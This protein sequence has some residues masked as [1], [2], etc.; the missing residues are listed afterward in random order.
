MRMRIAPFL[1]AFGSGAALTLLAGGSAR[2]QQIDVNPPLPN[3]LLMVD[4][5]GSMERMIDGSLPEDTT[6]NACDI[7]NC[8]VTA[9]SPPTTA[10]TVATRMSPQTTYPPPNRWNTALQA[11]T[12]TPKNG[13]HCIAMSRTGGVSSTFQNEY[14]INGAAPY[15]TGFYLPYHR[16]V[17]IDP[18][19]NKPCVFA[20]GSL[21]GETTGGV[22][23]VPSNAG[24]SASSFPNGSIINRPYGQSVTTSSCNFAQNPD[25]LLD[26]FQ[27]LIRFG[28]M[29]FDQ[30][31]SAATGV[32]AVAGNPQVLP[33]AG[34][35]FTG[36]WSYFP[37]W[38]GSSASVPA[39]GKPLLCTS[40]A[41]TFEVGAR[42]PAAPPWEGRMMYFPSDE[43]QATRDLQSTNM[44]LV[45]NATRPYGGTPLAGMFADAQ[46][47]FTTDPNGPSNSSV[48]ALAAGGCRQQFII[49]L[50]DGAPNEDMRPEYLGG[51]LYS[52]GCGT[53]D[54]SSLGTCPYNHPEYTAGQ[55]ANNPPAGQKPV[56]T[57]VVGF[58]VSSALNDQG[59]NVNCEQINPVTD[60]ANLNANSTLAPCCELQKIAVAGAPPQP[61]GQTAHA[62][63]ANNA[64][65]LQAALGAI[66]SQIASMQ[67]TR[68]VPAYSSV[69]S[70]LSGTTTPNQETFYGRFSPAPAIPPPPGSLASVGE[71]WSGDITRSRFLC[72]SGLQAPAP[73]DDFANDLNT[74]SPARYFIAVPA[75][76]G[77]TATDSSA[78]LR[79]FFASATGVDGLGNASVTAYAGSASS[80]VN[81]I[82]PGA[83]N[84]SVG[85]CPY[86]SK[87]T[88]TTQSP[89]L[90]PTQCANMLMDFTFGQAFNGPADFTFVSRTS[91]AFGGVFH[92]IPVAVGPPSASLHDDSYNAFSTTANVVACNPASAN[93]A[94]GTGCR[95]N[96]LYAATTDGILHAFWTD[97]PSAT[98]SNNEMWAMVPPGVLPN[99]LSSYPAEDKFLLDGSPVV[100]DVV[101]DRPKGQA[102]DPNGNNPWSTMLVAGFGSTQKGYYAVDVTK[103]TVPVVTTA[104]T[105]G[106]VFKW[107]LT[108]M[109]ATNI[110]L[111]GQHGATPT[112]TTVFVGVPTPHEIG[113]AILPGGWDTPARTPIA[114]NQTTGCKRATAVGGDVSQSGSYAY[115]TNVQCWGSTGAASDPVVGR[116]V[117]IVRLDTGEVIATFMRKAD[118]PATDT[119]FKA[120]PFGGGSANASGRIID[121][122]FDSPMTGT[123]VVYPADVGAIATKAFISDQ[124]GTIWKL[125]LSSTDPSQWTG[126][127]FFDMYNQT[128]ETASTAWQDG[129]P[130]VV[131]MQIALDRTGALVLAAA[132]GPQDQFTSSG[133]YFVYSV[134]EKL[135]SAVLRS[136]VNWYLSSYTGPPSLTA[137]AGVMTASL[138]G[139]QATGERVSGPMV[140]FDGGL[141]F[142]TYAVPSVAN[143]PCTAGRAYLWGMD[144]VTPFD[145]TGLNL[146]EGGK[147]VLPQTTGTFPYLDLVAAG[148]VPGSAVVPGISVQATTACVTLGSST[149]AYVPGASHVEAQTFTAG[150][151]SLAGQFGSGSGSGVGT[152]S[153]S[154]PTPREPTLI[155][156]WASVVE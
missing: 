24:G 1:A 33:T 133:L 45:L 97:V 46:Y 82:L 113:V 116:S 19:G 35:A 2:A 17:A 77:A 30:D 114:P 143:L 41:L 42:N 127:L 12:G 107:Q 25:G 105:T 128:V 74:N 132:S 73:G 26:S 14:Q 123:A 131:P 18:T 5:S 7:S 59:M 43:T 75:M 142:T 93:A 138:S 58:A 153:L 32:T 80:V 115:R 54:G 88:F 108:T 136:S 34:A 51:G 67:T 120:T 65:D 27:D 50:T 84:L 135:Q 52:G 47:Y 3:V 6:E 72:G 23:T 112:I 140:I 104:P 152:F 141:Y 117:T 70:V 71:P 92:A 76:S 91:N 62:Y 22:G 119:L 111:F 20:P 109:P 125:D 94:T 96:L 150:S 85:S 10:C 48:D 156:S 16:A 100:K 28:L 129:Q 124:D 8:I 40:S 11:L 69:A 55:L 83:L 118:A 56:Y 98:T 68:T 44:Q 121:T 154:L 60:C 66:F 151:F 145:S 63:F 49:L 155:N 29:T 79:P 110:Q 53:G 64:G 9:G 139:T 134:S 147:V 126:K 21:P 81:N 38:D 15:D 146:S 57:Y 39:T 99:L 87:V 101:T 36:M 31:P 89:G 90:T 148:L 137:H 130:V 4:N 144:F 103:P 95:Q 106:P 122:P 86:T 149:A 61:P 78:T 37:G 102:T 13:Y